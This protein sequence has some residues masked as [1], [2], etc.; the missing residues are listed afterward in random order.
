MVKEKSP[1]TKFTHVGSIVKDINKAVAHYE[2]MGMGPFKRFTLPGPGFEFIDW[3]DDKLKFECAY[4]QIGSEIGLELFQ[5]VSGNI[6]NKGEHIWHIGYDVENMD[7]TIAWMAERG[8][9][10]IA[11]TTYVDGSRECRFGTAEPGGVLIQTHELVKGS[12]LEEFFK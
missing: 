12:H 4:G 2:K 11:T 8:F 10:V 5:P 1:L 7:K 3:P 6:G 9:K